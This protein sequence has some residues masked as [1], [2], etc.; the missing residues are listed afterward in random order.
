MPTVASI[1]HNALLILIVIASF[2]LII[3][4]HEL[5]HF[6][7][8]KWRGLKIERFQIWFGKPIWKKEI[9]GV[10]YGLGWIPAGGFVALPQ[11]APMEAVEGRSSEDGEPL[12]P[13]SPLDKIIVAVAGPLF[14]ML[15]AFAAAIV[16]WKAGK[17]SNFVPTQVV[18]EVVPGGPAAKSG[19]RA[20]D[21]ILAINGKPVHGFAGD[22]DC[23]SESI[24]LSRGDQIHFTIERA[25]EAKPVEVISNFEIAPTKWYQRSAPRQVGIV[26]L[27]E[28]VVVSRVIK[29]SPAD[30]AGLKEDDRLVSLNGESIKNADHFVTLAKAA[31]AQELT[32]VYERKG[33]QSSAK[34]TAKMPKQA[35]DMRPQLGIASTDAAL[36]NKNFEYPSPWKQVSGCSRMMWA[37]ITS[38]I[39]PKSSIGIQHL[40]GPIG[41]GKLNFHL[42]ESD[43]PFHNTMWFMVLFNVNLAIFNLFP[44]PVLDG[45]HITLAILEWVTRRPA[46]ARV[47][48]VIQTAFALLLIGLFLYVSSKDIGSNIKEDKE[49]PVQV[50]FEP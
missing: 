29:N 21:K 14:S 41:V 23:I 38:L 5:G 7:A 43:Y 24:V 37:T 16:V 39:S 4:V 17:P 46:R 44:L 33:V 13:I 25:G 15:L 31:S 2:N 26:P 9:N 36:F 30:K 22:L 12:P 50:I 34:M 28:Q 6:L 3:F 19:I 18:G 20:G 32:L 11:M 48:E 47:L 35:P 49:A 8:G 40:S 42:L 1:L 45:G 27:L 10:Q